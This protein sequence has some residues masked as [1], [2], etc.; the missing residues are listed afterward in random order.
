MLDH[1]LGKNPIFESFGSSW[2]AWAVNLIQETYQKRITEKQQ[3]SRTPDFMDKVIKAQKKF[4]DIV[5]DGMMNIYL[6]GNVVAGS[7]TTATAMCSAIYYVLKK[8]VHAK[9]CEELKAADLPLPAKW[10]D[11]QKLPFFTT[12][13]QEAKRIQ[14]GVGMLLERSRSIIVNKHWLHI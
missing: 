13:M 10:K 1:V 5:H 3:P 12:V 8:P 6:L 14:P 4:P 11:L 9:L 2:L 7:D